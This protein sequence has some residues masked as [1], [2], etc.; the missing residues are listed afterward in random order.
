MSGTTTGR[1]SIFCDGAC[2]GNGT[3][4]AVAGWAWAYWPGVARGEPTASGSARLGAPA[5]NQ[6]AELMA[7]FEALRWLQ[8]NGSGSPTTIYTDSQYAIKCTTVWGPG[9][10]RKGWTRGS[11]EPLQNLDIIKPLVD[12]WSTMRVPLVHVRGHQTGSTPEVWGN[13]WVD[14]A[15]VVAAGGSGEDSYGGG[16]GSVG[17]GLFTEAALSATA[18]AIEHLVDARYRASSSSVSSSSASSTPIPSPAA[19]PVFTVKK[20]TTTSAV[21]KQMDIRNWF[22]GMK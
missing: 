2:R 10:K 16:G 21:I 6:R 5:T 4:H 20:T 1:A 18:D 22:G 3:R 13:N 12:L 7:L 14:R 8:K 11:G 9:W 17:I 15:A 19:P